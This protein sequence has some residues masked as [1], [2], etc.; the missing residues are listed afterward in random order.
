M[1][2]VPLLLEVEAKPVPPN[3]TPHPPRITQPLVVPYVH[4]TA[5]SV[6]KG[7]PLKLSKS[8]VH[9]P[10][11]LLIMADIPRPSEYE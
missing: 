6:D 8:V 9:P 11:K 5:P 2:Y 1:P 10:F 4:V 3:R 7:N